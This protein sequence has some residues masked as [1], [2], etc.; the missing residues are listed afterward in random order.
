MIGVERIGRSVHLTLR[1][2]P[3]NVID[4]ASCTALTGQLLELKQDESIAALFLSGDGRGFSAGASVEE[5]RRE[6]VEGMLDALMASCRELAE[7]PAPT[8]ALVHGMCLGGAMELIAFCDFVVADPEAKFGQPEIQ[9]AFFPPLACGRLPQLIGSQRAA[10]LNLTGEIVKAP[11]A[12]ALG[13]A[14]DLVE[15]DEWPAYIERFNGLSAPVLRLS[16]QALLKAG[17]GPDFTRLDSIKDLFLTELYKLE[18]LQEG[19]NSFAE[20]RKPEWKHR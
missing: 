5:H 18:D 2:P 9:L 8:V 14:Q 17:G 13:L 20:K 19:I 4:T 10:H 1:M 15:K 11:E 16:K 3:V 6:N 7:F 12:K